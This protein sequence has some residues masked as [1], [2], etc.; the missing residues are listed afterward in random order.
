MYLNASN[1]GED[2]SGKFTYNTMFE[3]MDKIGDYW[4]DLIEQVVPATTIW[5]GCDNSGKIYRNTIFDNNKFNYKRYS[6]NFIS[7][8]ECSLSGQTDFSI[9]SENTYSVVEEKPIYPNNP[10]INDKKTEILNKEIEIALLKKRYRQ[11][12]I[13]FYVL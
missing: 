10:Q 3:F 12:K 1:C 9:G 11:K 2:L 6:L 7:T 8:E 13:V 4:L 5:E